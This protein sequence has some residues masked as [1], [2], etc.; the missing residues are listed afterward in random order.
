MFRGFCKA[1][2]EEANSGAKPREIEEYVDQHGQESPGF[3]TYAE[4][5][6]IYLQCA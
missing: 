6:E 1:L 5:R 4:F 2:V 3:L